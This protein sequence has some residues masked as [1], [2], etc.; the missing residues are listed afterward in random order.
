[1]GISQAVGQFE[2]QW[3]IIVPFKLLSVVVSG[4]SLVF[5]HSSG[6]ETLIVPTSY[7]SDVSH[8]VIHLRF[9]DRPPDVF[10]CDIDDLGF[11]LNLLKP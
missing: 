9:I 8:T 10:V 11:P 1:M 3:L 5:V 6:K 2:F 4:V 7:E